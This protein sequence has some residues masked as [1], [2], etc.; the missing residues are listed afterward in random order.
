MRNSLFSIRISR[1]RLYCRHSGCAG[2]QRHSVGGLIWAVS[3]YRSSIYFDI[4]QCV[5]CQQCH[6]ES[7]SVSALRCLVCCYHF[8]F[9]F[10][11]NATSLCNGDSLLIL[12]CFSSNDRRTCCSIR[13]L[14]RITIYV[15]AEV[16][17]WT[18]I[19]SNVGQ[20]SILTCFT[21]KFYLISACALSI[22]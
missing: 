22:F 1:Y 3:C 2:W 4:F 14:S 6:F 17:N 20:L 12:L 7:N 15:R 18:T 19:H 8:D 13:Q 9:C 16:A 10:S 5:V 21:N 11:T